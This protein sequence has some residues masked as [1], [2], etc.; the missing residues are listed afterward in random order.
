MVFLLEG[1]IEK[2]ESRRI[3]E[4]KLPNKCI[5]TITANTERIA[6]QE[7]GA[8]IINMCFANA[9]VAIAA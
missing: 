2:L 9:P 4:A 8:H 7:E 6:R 3:K 5:Q 1:S